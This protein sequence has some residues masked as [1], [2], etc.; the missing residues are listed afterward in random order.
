[1]GDFQL[2]VCEFQDLTR[3]RWTL[4]KGGGTLVA[5]HEV[6]LDAG[7]W[8]FEAFT[9]LL[10][11]LSWHVAPDRRIDD[12][13]R[14]V[15]EVGSWIGVEVFGA[16]AEVLVRERPASV[17]VVVPAEARSLLFCPLELAHLDGIP[18][19]V[20]GVTLIMDVRTSCGVYGRHSAPDRRKAVPDGGRLRVLGLFSLPEGGQPLNL[21][22]ERH[23][24]VR[25]VRGIAA[26]GKAADV[27]ALQYGV[28]REQLQGVLEEAE[29]WDVIHI[30]GHGAPGELLLET[31]A[32]K[33]DPVGADDLA[34]LLDLA[35]ERVKLVT[36]SACWSAAVPAAEERRLLGMP[37]LDQQSAERA[38]G[39]SSA[40]GALANKLADRLDCAV[41]AMRYPVDDD[42]AIALSGKL[43]DLL[44]GKG[45]PLPQ[46][47]GMTL[48]Q[49]SG[50]RYPALSV[51]APA[52]FGRTAVELK[53]AAPERGP[54]ATYDTAALKMARF[55][56]QPDLF[57]GRTGVMA[58][59]SA[60]LAAQSG[61]PGVLLHGMPG[62]GKT[63]CA[64]E[65]AYGH[66][67]GFD[68]L[69]WFK[70][71]DEGME[72]SGALTDFALTLECDL[73]GFQMAHTL[74]DEATLTGF[75][76][77][78]TEL[79]E[80]RRLLI[81]IDNAE[82]LLNNRGQWRDARW[83]QV[84]GALSSHAGLGRVIVT[85]RRVPGGVTRLRVDAVDALSVDEALLLVRE[86]PH[87]QALIRGDL[88]GIDRD[89]SRWLA[90]GVLTVTQGHP[91][92]LEL[93]DGQA[94]HPERLAKLVEAGDQ[95]WREQGGLPEGF[96]TADG[97]TATGEDYLHVLDAWTRAVSGTLSPGERDLF[98]FLCCLEEA[99]RERPVVE[100]VWPHLTD[101]L[102][103]DGQS[104]G[105]DRALA[106]VTARGLAAI[107][108]GTSSQ[109]QSY[110]IHPGIA[111]AGRDQAGKPVQDAADA[112]AAAF[113]GAVYANA[114]GD[115][116]DTG[117]NTGLLVRAG[118]AAVP[119]LM[120]QQQWTKAAFLLE[121]S[122]N[123]EPSRA[124]AAAM[125][126][127]IQQITCH[128]PR[129][130]GV[131]AL[132]L[133]VIDPAAAEKQLRA[134]LDAAMDR[135]DYHLASVAAGQLI[136][137]CS[138]DG[139]LAEA[140]ILA[141]QMISYTEQ[142]SLGPWTELLGQLKRAEVLNAMGRAAEALAEVQRL[143]DH[144][145]T[146][147]GRPGPDEAVVPWHMREAL[148]KA[149]REAAVQLGQ[150][151]DALDLNAE[152]I[153]SLR[154]R[155]APAIDTAGARYNDYYP[156][157]CLGRTEEALDLLLECR[158]VFQDTPDTGALGQILTAL[159]HTEHARG[160]GEAAI[161]LQRDA[162]RYSY[163]I[164]DVTGITAGYRNLGSYLH[165]YARQPAPAF[166]YHL[167]AALIRALAS[168]AG[169][170]ESIRDATADL[171]EFG[172]ATTPPPDLADLCRRIGDI[173]GTEP[174]RLIAQLSPGPGTAER[175]LRELLARVRALAEA[176]SRDDN[177]G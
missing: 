112:E 47:V 32:G 97:T 91:K 113:W 158:Q 4:T 133:Q 39:D 120:R 162:L 31:A 83:G 55:P 79:I 135:R 62:G 148:L 176:P 59:A 122:F 44:V 173:P 87:L 177:P 58:R 57:V 78:L 10:R 42:F 151:D 66:E 134:H 147:P 102:G 70:A 68:R 73:P 52:I 15:H 65:L 137:L 23:A 18:L 49:L 136:D 20:Q 61:V 145:R 103:R 153:A 90:L 156:L 19:S 33:P 144:M 64:L 41:L 88:D 93:A 27:R 80:H 56:P 119:Y 71:P 5:D 165:L 101:R 69:V 149:A 24:L 67:H 170:D 111:A 94:A 140:L 132:V 171:R 1:M 21:R 40:P 16:V 54:S 138:G 99:D 74:A 164:G 160:H 82:S 127:A 150:W 9:D 89:A 37:V 131:L 146:L 60:A 38:P 121:H 100:T 28:T 53:L 161:G 154:D 143:R 7:C 95:T 30:S 75:L 2:Q 84:I 129:Q 105:L 29:G 155:R 43:Y 175:A 141:G 34:D 107:H 77:R 14:I 117:V 17:R 130:V 114:S 123:L 46:A 174:A 109:A 142:A 110:T 12:E 116:G 63:A 139:R 6:R 48:R 13:A 11:Y 172:A 45:Q 51:A 98:W 72:I 92:L 126:S 3:W 50:K 96:F 106:S 167:A 168:A 163:L 86:L 166:A 125:L 157:L 8:Q 81:V 76:P 35:V 36:V 85:S 152:V 159:A 115:S 118:L 26:V 124:N 25:L 108:D 128:D 22:R 104:P 169:T